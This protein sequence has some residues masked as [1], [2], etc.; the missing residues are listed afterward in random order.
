MKASRNSLTANCA[1]IKLIVILVTCWVCRRST[2]PE[3][4]Y[5]GTSELLMRRELATS[6][7]RR[8]DIPANRIIMCV[9]ENCAPQATHYINAQIGALYDNALGCVERHSKG[10]KPDED[11][12]YSFALAEFYFGRH[13][14]RGQASKSD[15]LFHASFG[16]PSVD[17]ICNHDAILR[18]NLT[19]GHFNTDYQK[20]T[21]EL[22]PASPERNRPFA[23]L[24][25]KYRVP[26]TVTGV[27]GRDNTIGNG[28]HVINMLVFDYTK[29]QLISV[30]PEIEGGSQALAFYLS[31]YLQLLQNAGHHVVFSLPDFD[32]DRLHVSIDFSTAGQSLLE[33]DEV[34][35]VSVEKINAFLSASWLKSAILASGRKGEI[36]DRT[37]LSLAEYRSTWVL[38]DSTS[39]FHV[40]LGAPR[41]RAVCNQEV[42]LFFTVDEVLFYE[43]TDF[44]SAPKASFNN[45]EIAVLANVIQLKEEN[46]N[47]TRIKLDLRNSCR[48]VPAYCDFQGYDEH[49]EV[50][51]RFWTRLIDF[52][53][54]EYVD[55]LESAQY[56][57]IYHY[58]VRWAKTI[59]I[60]TTTTT[61]EET[62]YDEHGEWTGAT[63]GD[64]SIV[65]TGTSITSSWTDITEKTDMQDF[66][67]IITITQSAINAYFRTIFSAAQ[68]GKTTMLAA[69]SYDEYFSASFQPV[70][71]R[72]LSNRKALV[73]VHLR[74]GY[75][76]TLKNWVPWAESEQYKFED[77]RLA[78]EVDLKFGKREELE[79]I[80]ST[81]TSVFEESFAYKHHGK[82][83]D[84][85]FKHIYL[86]LKTADFIYEFSTFDGLFHAQ[87]RRAIDKVQAIVT[88]LQSYWF[89]QLISSGYHVLYTIPIWDTKVTRP[90]HALTDAHF[91]VYSKTVLDLYNWGQVTA[92]NEPVIAILGMMNGRIPR[93]W[94]LSY[95]TSWIMRA[96][97]GISYGT[98][99]LSREIFLTER[100]RPLLS[101]INAVTTIV[102]L[103]FAIE[104]GVWK[105]ELSTWA[106][107]T[108]RR[109]SDSNWVLESGEPGVLKYHWKHLDGWT[110]RHE[111]S[112]NITN[113]AYTV[114]CTT[115]NYLEIPTVFKSGT[116]DIKLRGE[117]SLQLGVENYNNQKWMAH[118]SAS[119][120]ASIAAH[121]E[122]GGL[123][124]SIVGSTAPTFQKAHAEG[125]V[126]ASL[127]TDPE[128]LLKQHLPSAISLEGVLQEFKAFENVWQAVYP[129]TS[130]FILA[131]PVFDRKGDI[132][133][134]LRPHSQLSASTPLPSTPRR[135]ASGAQS[136][137]V[138]GSGRPSLFNRPSL[139]Q[140]I[141][142]VAQGLVSGETT[143]GVAYSNGYANGTAANG[144]T[145]TTTVTTT[146]TKSNVSTNF[147]TGEVRSA[148]I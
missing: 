23:G 146:T 141:E 49:D 79:G 42:I 102:P 31:Q 73:W 89:P 53:T 39:H 29:A 114:L 107:S 3:I 122:V 1:E 98:V 19:E 103:P 13:R 67:E 70:T 66:D 7:L 135:I 93:S 101:R 91:E 108:T 139:M 16:K 34:Y 37:L 52:F 54:T 118:S 85:Y 62:G 110:Y 117:V 27:S 125:E 78:F 86:D 2:S 8:S 74:D 131:Q 136:R 28:Q 41:I 6:I 134:E 121:S 12:K 35:G 10:L 82:S 87:D 75:L 61:T 65:Q 145:A 132:L 32:D 33:L 63:G 109:G 50:S 119:W 144:Y 90:A 64:G 127:Y 120:S 124:V 104:N 123:H 51:L 4:A 44:D 84:R 116:L 68:T 20:V 95:S 140:K 55:I 14:G 94:H 142:T 128:K 96:T 59:S 47:V 81:W 92:G 60:T 143:N 115:K 100:L 25:V 15:M 126:V 148:V 38:S 43:T 76:K 80:S 130:A 133:F 56:H 21:T 5:I 99:A 77:W 97:R 22:F 113:G 26:F 105:L 72:L 30:H 111:G 137:S 18:L 112:D 24:E 57:V 147:A 71:I 106:D 45:W 36:A 17:F 58:D 83:T 46:N 138:S 69:W 88:Y 40:K 129:G 11:H 48:F 9:G